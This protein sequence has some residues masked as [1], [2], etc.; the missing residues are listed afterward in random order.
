MVYLKTYYYCVRSGNSRIFRNLLTQRNV[1]HFLEQDKPD[2]QG[3][4]LNLHLTLAPSVRDLP[5][6]RSW[7]A[8]LVSV[9]WEA[10]AL[11]AQAVATNARR[12]P[13]R[14]PLERPSALCALKAHIAVI[15]ALAVSSRMLAPLRN[16]IKRGP[17]SAQRVISVASGRRNARSVS[18]ASI[19]M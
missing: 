19:L 3:D 13:I 17:S 7:V 10:N 5:P 6:W 11:G 4:V 2:A 18:L 14:T 12:V 15:R 9:D 8:G 16:L 1:N